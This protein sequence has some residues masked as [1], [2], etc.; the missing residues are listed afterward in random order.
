ME[1]LYDL[2]AQKLDPNWNSQLRNFNTSETMGT[3]ARNYLMPVLL[4]TVSQ[5]NTHIENFFPLE[6]QPEIFGLHKSATQK[7]TT[8][9]ANFIMDRTYK[10]QFVVKKTYE[11]SIGGVKDKSFRANTLLFKHYRSKLSKMLKLIP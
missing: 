11:Q 9:M 1:R 5:M 4:E 10:H 6:D 2:A 3:H 7:A 8:D